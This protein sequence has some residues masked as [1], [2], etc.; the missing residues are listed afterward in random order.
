MAELE[1]QDQFG[2]KDSS[3][4]IFSCARSSLEKIVIKEDQLLIHS[5]ELISISLKQPA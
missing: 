1:Q 3:S 4:C 2:E 5:L